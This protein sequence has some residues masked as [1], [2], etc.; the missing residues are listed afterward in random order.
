MI[1]YKEA[2]PPAGCLTVFRIRCLGGLTPFHGLEYASAN[3]ISTPPQQ[4]PCCLQT[5]FSDSAKSEPLVLFG[6][7][8]DSFGLPL[9]WSGFADSLT[10]LAEHFTTTGR[11]NA[12][13][14]HRF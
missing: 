8:A 3:A 1:R 7:V 4:K 9:I 10:M 13:T 6:P 12:Q 2:R 5:T 14:A 11:T